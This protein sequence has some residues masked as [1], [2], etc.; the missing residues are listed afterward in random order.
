MGDFVKCVRRILPDFLTPQSPRTLMP[1][2][3]WK[4]LWTTEP[5]SVAALEQQ[6]AK[7]V[8][9]AFWAMTLDPT[10]KTQL[11]PLDDVADKFKPWMEEYDKKTAKLRE[12]PKK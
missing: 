7:L 2:A 3:R 12:T 1:R 4:E 9:Q 11:R 8:E 6:L 10:Y 5:A